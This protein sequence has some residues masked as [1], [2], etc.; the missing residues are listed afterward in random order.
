[1]ENK[2][3]DIEKYNAGPDESF[4]NNQYIAHTT[5]WDL[6]QVSPP[7][8]TYF[9]HLTNKHLRILIPGCGNTYEAEY[10]LQQGFTDITV[11]DIAP[12][13]IEQLKNKFAANPAI[14]IILGDFFKH[15][16]EYD[17]I[18]EQTFFCAIDPELR[19]AYVAKMKEL[20]ATNGKLAGVL[21]DREFEQIG[22]PFGGN[23]SEYKQLFENDFN[24]IKFELCY[25]S[26]YKRQG[27]ELFI[28][29]QKKFSTNTDIT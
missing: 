28:I 18:V 29:L 4:W 15:H 16:G 3:N 17:L 22:P 14:K 2:K 26:F 8:K 19:K 13:L 25:N 6:G 10:L 21:F 1:M 7:L 27:T 20:L 24:F 12:A 23:K 9:D 11:I 5:G